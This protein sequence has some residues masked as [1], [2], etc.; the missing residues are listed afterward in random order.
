MSEKITYEPINFKRLSHVTNIDPI[1]RETEN[2]HTKKE[3]KKVK[4]LA[5]FAS[6]AG[7]LHRRKMFRYIRNTAI[8]VAVAF[9]ILFRYTAVSDNT[10]KISKLQKEYTELSENNINLQ[11]E[12]D[13]L[14]DSDSIEEA[15]IELGMT[16]PSKSQKITVDVVGGDYVE[17]AGGDVGQSEGSSQFYATMIET[18]GNVLEYLY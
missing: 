17:V 6:D 5:D 3:N 15:A 13:S 14:T 10:V 11:C 2:K 12:I 1:P 4:L 9:V 7:V 8:V 18:L 16:K